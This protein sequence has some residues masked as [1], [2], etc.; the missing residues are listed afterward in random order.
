MQIQHGF[1]QVLFFPL[2][3]PTRPGMQSAEPAIPAR[4]RR[5]FVITGTQLA[6]SSLAVTHPIHLKAQLTQLGPQ[7]IPQQGVVFGEQEARGL[8][9]F[10][11]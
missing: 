4:A 6:L 7:A 5:R 11:Q 2:S 1:I 3:L 10:S 9:A 8:F